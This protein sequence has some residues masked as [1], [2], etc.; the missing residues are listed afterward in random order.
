[1]KL[2]TPKNQIKATAINQNFIHTAIWQ[3]KDSYLDTI[4]PDY[5]YVPLWKVKM[6]AGN[7]FPAQDLLRSTNLAQEM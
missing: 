6:E 2:L 5:Q 7:L 1:M 4:L 3:Q